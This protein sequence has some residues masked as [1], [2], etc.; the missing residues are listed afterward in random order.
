M[1]DEFIATQQLRYVRVVPNN[2]FDYVLPPKLQQ[3]WYSVVDEKLIEWRD[4]PIVMEHKK[5]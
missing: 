2:N 3:K 1:T 4:I 5:D